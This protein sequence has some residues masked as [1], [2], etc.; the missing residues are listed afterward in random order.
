MITHL[1]S[2]VDIGVQADQVR[3]LNHAHM[4]RIVWE[5]C[6]EQVERNTLARL[7]RQFRGVERSLEEIG[8]SLGALAGGQELFF[9]S[10]LNLTQRMQEVF[11]PTMLE[12]PT[13]LDA[14]LLCLTKEN[15]TPEAE[16]YCLT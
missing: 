16:E 11:I 2:Y 3:Q 13:T 10:T 9:K 6:I 4:L 5:T 7:S 1:P 8:S 15:E 12:E 14:E